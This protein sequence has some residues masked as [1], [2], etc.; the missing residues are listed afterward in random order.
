MT[1]TKLTGK[2]L[3]QIG[4]PEGKVIG[5]ALHILEKKYKGKSKKHKLELLQRILETPALYQKHEILAPIAIELITKEPPINHFELNTKRLSYKTYGTEGIE[6]GAINQMEIAM[7]LPITVGG[8]LMADAHQGYGLPIGGVLAT[9][10]TVIPYGVG[11]D[12]GCRM[13]LSIYNLSP[14]FLQQEAEKLK[15][16]L[17]DNT[18]FGYA[19]FKNPKDHEI[20]ER[21]AFDEIQILNTLKDKAYRQIGSSGGGN[22]FVEFGVVEIPEKENGLPV[23]SGKY[24]A[25]LSHSGSR[26]MGAEIARYYTKIAREKTQLPGEAKHLAWLDLDTEAGQE[27]WL[28]MTLAGDYASA[29]HHQIHERMAKALGEDHLL[30][31]ENHHNFAWKEQDADGN[32]I[33]V[34]R[35]GATPAGMGAL[36]IIPGSMTSPG[37]IVKGKGERLSLNSASHGA[38]RVMSRRKAKQTLSKHDVLSHL[39]KAGISLIGSGLD[40]APM[41]YKDIHQVMKHQQALVE[42]MGIFHPKIVRMCGDSKFGEVD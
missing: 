4:F 10:N 16:I 37:F 9:K 29:C 21:P 33:I 17:V 3:R 40:E 14:G 42:V 28:A 20:L 2:E 1:S 36:G 13:C 39:K 24:L 35:K 41:V 32:E 34:H 22:H 6:P 19:T 38:G 18:K 8:A 5:T 30:M 15:K 11:V 7:K 27:Y 25:V 26:G 23:A 12:I 31:V